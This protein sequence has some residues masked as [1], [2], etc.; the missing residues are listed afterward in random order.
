MP[1]IPWRN[2]QREG[3]GGEPS[4]LSSLRGEMDRLVE[5]FV[6]DPMAVLDWPFTGRGWM[7]AVD[8]SED[9]K[10]VTVR[11]EVPGIKPEDIEL[12]V[13]GNQLTISG[14]KK[15]EHAEKGKGVFHSERRYGSFRRMIP[16]PEGVDANQ[17]EAEYAHGILTIQLQ[18]APTAAPKRIEVRPK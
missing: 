16:L 11:A 10:Q 1:L 13:S 18:K 5:S 17:V 15:E 2:K 12:T 3:D 8:V 6:R 7:P 14:E 4:A 9:D